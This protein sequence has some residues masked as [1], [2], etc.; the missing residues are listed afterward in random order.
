MQEKQ[1]KY[2]PLSAEEWEQIEAYQKISFEQK[3]AMLDRMR[4][5]MFKLWKENPETYE[6]AQKFRRGEI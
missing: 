3:L 6:A 5:F 1:R 4:S 2:P